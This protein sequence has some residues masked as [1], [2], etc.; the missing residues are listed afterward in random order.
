M[1][2]TACRSLLSKGI[3]CNLSTSEEQTKYFVVSS[4][5]AASTYRFCLFVIHQHTPS[6][7][8]VKTMPTKLK[9]HLIAVALLMHPTFGLC[10]W[11]SGG[12]ET[13]GWPQP[14]FKTWV[15]IA[16][17]I[18]IGVAVFFALICLGECESRRQASGYGI[19]TWYSDCLRLACSLLRGIITWSVNYWRR[20]WSKLQANRNTSDGRTWYGYE[21]EHG[22]GEQHLFYS[23]WKR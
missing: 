8:T 11:S 23:V 14:S 15:K 5:P 22:H 17:G 6:P 10:R 19:K 12:S 20:A 3:S 7:S 13:S 1:L 2:D 9:W 21:I 18:V 16:G 4:L